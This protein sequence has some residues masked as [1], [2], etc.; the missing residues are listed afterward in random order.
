MAE[1]SLL[2]RVSFALALC[3][4]RHSS[5]TCR[6]GAVWVAHPA[7]QPDV[8]PLILALAGH[9]AAQFFALCTRLSTF[10]LAHT[11]SVQSTAN[12][13]RIEDGEFGCC[14]C[15]WIEPQAMEGVR[16]TTE[17]RGTCERSCTLLFHH[18]SVGKGS[19]K[20]E[21]SAGLQQRTGQAQASKPHRWQVAYAHLQRLISAADFGRSS[22][23]RNRFSIARI[24]PRLLSFLAGMLCLDPDERLT[25]IQ[26]LVHPYFSEV[27][28]F[29]IPLGSVDDA[30]KAEAAPTARH[31]FARTSPAVPVSHASAG[32]AL[33]V[34]RGSVA[35]ALPGKKK[36]IVASLGTLVLKT[37][38]AKG[39]IGGRGVRDTKYQQGVTTLANM[40]TS[41]KVPSYSG[42]ASAVIIGAHESTGA[43]QNSNK[44][45]PTRSCGATPAPTPALRVEKQTT[46]TTLNRARRT[47]APPLSVYSPGSCHH[48]GTLIASV[49]HSKIPASEASPTTL[50][51]EAA[52]GTVDTARG[53]TNILHGV[54]AADA[55]LLSIRQSRFIA[56]AKR[57]LAQGPQYSSF[58]ATGAPGPP[59][60]RNQQST[61]PCLPGWPLCVPT[62]NRA[63]DA[64][65]PLPPVASITS[66]DETRQRN[67]YLTSAVLAKLNPRVARQVTVGAAMNH[68]HLG[69]D[70]KIT[71]AKQSRCQQASTA[72]SDSRRKKAKLTNEKLEHVIVDGTPAAT[73]HPAA[74]SIESS[75]GSCVGEPV[76][77]DTELANK[78]YHVSSQRG[79]EGCQSGRLVK[80][81]KS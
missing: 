14:C 18:A 10:D 12:E 2:P 80:D 67:R 61:P 63:H 38:I 71:E 81:N 69:R 64:L 58:E 3:L 36:S 77:S 9:V 32:E 45:T 21:K 8:W 60:G 24:D 22:G 42:N 17:A 49:F 68:E 4:C 53:T 29:V 46:T 59:N 73:P 62:T 72:G 27:F 52:A 19:S 50:H 13:S 65:T 76:Y 54:D 56:A 25:P 20:V 16:E 31:D 40:S 37:V 78:G 28:P 74:A 11:W 41:V 75:Q 55:T 6:T 79:G 34:P 66:R 35:L 1:K 39:N 47:S 57:G 23:G 7:T 5:F 33:P 44:G 48:A 43:H 15:C 70:N 26:A 51:L 30:R